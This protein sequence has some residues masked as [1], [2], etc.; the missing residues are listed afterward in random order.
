MYEADLARVHDLGFTALAEA[1]ARMVLDESTPGVAVDLGCGGGTL[2]GALADAGYA[3]HGYDVSPAMVALAQRRVPQGTFEVADVSRAALPVCDV[4][5]AVGEV[6][7]YACPDAVALQA[8]LA[9]IHGGL[10][11]GGL[12]LFDVAT[13]GRAEEETHAKRSGRGWRVEAHASEADGWLTRTIDTWVETPVGERHAREVHRLR[14]FDVDA[15]LDA[16]RRAGFLAEHLAGY[17]DHAFQ[18]GWDAF[19]ARRLSSA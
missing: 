14:L 5:T 10:R 3:V 19:M 1:A 16:L 9:R 13:T 18:H 6:F 4:V 2:S 8:M 12:L 7:C 15:V 11:P 17:D